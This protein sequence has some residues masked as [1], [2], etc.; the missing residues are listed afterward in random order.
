[1]RKQ[2]FL[3]CSKTYGFLIVA[4]MLLLGSCA[5]GYDS[6]DGF[7]VGVNN[8]QVI[9]PSAD[10]VRFVVNT[11]G[12]NATI[13]WPLVYGA[14]GYEVT[15]ENVDNPDSAYVIDNY[16]N[17]LV[18]GSSMTVTVTEDSRYK[19][20]IRSIGDPKRGN[21]DDP[22]AVVVNLSTLV[23]AIATIPDGSDIYTFIQDSVKKD[24]TFGQIPNEVAI[25]LVSGGKYTLSGPIDFA[26]QKLTFRGDKVK[27]AE[28][29]VTGTG[30]L[31][32]YSGLKIKF[33][34][35]DMS[36]S[37]AISFISMT[38]ANLPVT[39][40]SQNLGYTRAGSPIND[41][42]IVQD[43][44]YIANCWFKNLPNSFLYDNGI[45][46][47]YWHFVI[48]DCIVQMRNVGTYPF[49]NLQTRGRA[50]KNIT[51]QNS[52]LYNTGD[53]SAY[54]MRYSNS[55]NSNPQKIFG[56]MSS[57]YSST[58]ITFS[59]ATL[60]KTYNR[61]QFANNLNGTGMTVNVDHCIFYDCYEPVR[62]AFSIGA[63][64]TFKFNFW[65]AVTNPTQN[66]SEPTRTDN[67]GAPFASL[68]DPKFVGD[69]T[70]SL[71]FALPNG[72][73][74]FTPTEY[75]ITSNMGGDPRWLIK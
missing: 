59:K 29:K 51:V 25:E 38:S 62:R 49:V 56:D 53:C 23:P 2:S 28:V 74:D 71:D 73:I 31:L 65:Y 50:V 21:T 7:D 24:T 46:C 66:S 12:T 63:M 4:F 42:Y 68:Y 55:S 72:G 75:E 27:R 30:G 11:E 33:I 10:S 13:S 64:K 26:G 39:I 67:S 41:I 6:P 70:Q 3:K 48:T 19:L 57:F 16:S 32:T 5:Q 22:N 36:E 43:P 15:F 52:T 45:T 37:T 34:N 9:T 14:K 40:R 18:D 1:M 44:I 17:T 20:T 35:F 47:A 60:S 8:Q 58:S 61:Q 69:V 54:F